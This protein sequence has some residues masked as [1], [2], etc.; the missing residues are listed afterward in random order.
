MR[1]GRRRSRARQAGPAIAVR[2]ATFKKMRVRAILLEPASPRRARPSSSTWSATRSSP[3]CATGVDSCCVG[4]PCSGS[5]GRRDRARVSS[6]IQRAR[7]KNR[8]GPP[9]RRPCAAEESTVGRSSSPGCRTATPRSVAAQPRRARLIIRR[10]RTSRSRTCSR[11]VARAVHAGVDRIAVGA[12]ECTR[13][14]SSASTHAA[15]ATVGLTTL[16][17]D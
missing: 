11:F 5:R 2:I 6:P 1:S 8:S 13:P 7:P 12:R 16:R 3:A 14:R 10:T 15:C 4:R 9:P 17:D